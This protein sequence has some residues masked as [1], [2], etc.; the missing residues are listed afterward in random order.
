MLGC[1]LVVPLEPGLDVGHLFPQSQVLAWQSSEE[2]LAQ[3]LALLQQMVGTALQPDQSS[4]PLGQFLV[5]QPLAPRL[6]GRV[7]SQAAEPQADHSFQVVFQLETV[8]LR[9]EGRQPCCQVAVID[10]A[11]VLGRVP[12]RVAGSTRGSGRFQGSSATGTF[13][14]SPPATQ[15]K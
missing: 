3:V 2:L 1:S 5:Q 7:T 11:F 9:P 15:K 6:Q 4:L 8:P 10:L 13:R 12:T 14:L